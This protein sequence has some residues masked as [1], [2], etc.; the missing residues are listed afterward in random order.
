MDSSGELFSETGKSKLPPIEIEL[1]NPDVR[2]PRHALRTYSKPDLEEIDRE[3]AR[4]LESDYIVPSKTSFTSPLMV[5]RNGGKVRV[6][7]DFRKLNALLKDSK[8]V[9]PVIE[10]LVMGLRGSIVFSHL[11]LKKGYNQVE[12]AASS[13]KL[14][15]IITPKGI[16]E[17]TVLP[18]GIKPACWEFQ[19]RMEDIFK[20]LL[21]VC[22]LVYIDDIIVYTTDVESHMVA[23]EKVF[24]ILKAYN[25]R[26]NLEKCSFFKSE[27]DFLGF[28]ISKDKIT[29][30]NDRVE[31]IIKAARPSNVS[32]LRG[33][34][35]TLNYL[36]RFIPEFASIV[37]P[38]GTLLKGKANDKCAF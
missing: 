22:V 14:L 31:A 7:V 36:R 12:I 2:A 24:G 5:S 8:H 28:I 20:D 19:A 29:V 33:Y 38:F 16:F 4:L 13:R 23:L 3:L 18:F 1:K 35:G 10:D 26:L 34:L 37:S 15:G 11:D 27:I 21:H 32:E 30:S 6:C 9:M 25:L 17:F